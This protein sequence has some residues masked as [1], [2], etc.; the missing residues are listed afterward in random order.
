MCLLKYPSG[1]L[2]RSLTS[3]ILLT[4]GLLPAGLLAAETFTVPNPVIDTAAE[5]Y[6]SLFLNPIFCF[7]S[8]PTPGVCVTFGLY[9]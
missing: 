8:L 4:I 1:R 5:A 2:L 9:Y 3:V 6:H 7:Y